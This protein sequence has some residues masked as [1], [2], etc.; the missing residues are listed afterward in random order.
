MPPKDNAAVYALPKIVKHY[1]V[2]RSTLQPPEQAILQVLD[3][4]LENWHVL[5]VGVGAG[6]TTPHLAPRVKKYTAIDFSLA[7][8]E[9]C[10]AKWQ[11]EF[12]HAAFEVDDASD[13]SRFA[14]NSIHLVLFSFNGLDTLS[15]EKRIQALHEIHRVLK[16]KGYFCFSSHNLQYLPTFFS[17]HFRLHP[18]KFIRNIFGRQRLIAANKKQIS[19]LDTAN[20]LVIYDDVYDFGLH[21]YYVRPSFQANELRKHEFENI[22]FYDLAGKERNE[23]ELIDIKDSWIYY[24]SQKH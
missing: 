4:F 7:M 3:L 19:Q 12:P 9:A 22:R 23:S 10:R 8:I 14:D 24:L 1:S 2:Y 18:L 20:H 6:R 21:T 11:K 5:D 15:H 17:F 16:P 13:L